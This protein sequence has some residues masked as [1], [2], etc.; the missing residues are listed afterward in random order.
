MDMNVKSML[1][2]IAFATV[3]AFEANAE[4]VDAGKKGLEDL[5]SEYFL[6]FTISPTNSIS[7]RFCDRQLE[8]CVG[9]EKRYQHVS[10]E[11]VLTLLCC[12]MLRVKRIGSRFPLVVNPACTNIAEGVKIGDR[13]SMVV[14]IKTVAKH[15]RLVPGLR[16]AVDVI[17]G[18]VFEFALPYV[19]SWTNEVEKLV[20]IKGMQLAGA[21]KVEKVFAEN[22]LSLAFDNEDASPCLSTGNQ[23]IAYIYD[24]RGKSRRTS[25]VEEIEKFLHKRINNRRRNDFPYVVA[26]EKRDRCNSICICVL[27]SPG[28][29]YFFEFVEGNRLALSAAVSETDK[30]LEIVT[31]NSAG[32]IDAMWSDVI[33]RNVDGRWMPLVERE[34]IESLYLI[35]KKHFANLINFTDSL[36]RSK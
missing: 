11:T 28:R 23:N 31:Y 34:E 12:Q 27:A 16:Q 8:A 25:C 33:L 18:H 10:Q 35:A 30:I 32:L 22:L 6:E 19:N 36:V 2:V 7:M 21:L 15:Y 13:E 20:H 4:I 29:R 1:R 5:L 24:S 17:S 26:H 9:K 14:D 3:V